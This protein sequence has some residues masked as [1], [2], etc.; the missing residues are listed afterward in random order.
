MQT[1]PNR[2][3]H[4]KCMESLV[5]EHSEELQLVRMLYEVF[6]L[7]Q[8]QHVL[9]SGSLARVLCFFFRRCRY[10]D[11]HS[12]SIRKLHKKKKAASFASLSHY[13]LHSPPLRF[14]R[15]DNT[16]SRRGNKHEKCSFLIP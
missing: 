10:S 14:M 9:F 15:G 1:I 2:F 5:L 6:W 4:R 3:A 12:L 16:V 7:V 13:P 8:A 11:I